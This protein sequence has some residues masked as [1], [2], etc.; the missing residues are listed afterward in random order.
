MARKDRIDRGLFERSE[1]SGVWW[2]RYAGPDGREHMERGGTKTEARTLLERR[3]TERHLGTWKP[4]AKANRGRW[5]GH[6]RSVDPDGP[7]LGAFAGQWLQERTPHLTPLVLYDYGIL[8]NTKLLPHPIARKP[9]AKIDEGDIARLVKKLSEQR[10]RGGKVLSPRRV[11]MVISRLRTIFRTARRRKIIADDPMQYVENLRESKPEYDPFD[12]DEAISLLAAAKGWERAFL[13]CLVFAGL[14]PNEALALAWN[15]IDF[16]HGLIRV[17]RNLWR[18]F[19]FGLPKTRGA[20]REVEM[21][22]LVRRE[23]RAQRARSQLRGE[24]VFPSETATPIDL[25]NFRVRN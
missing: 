10:A 16:K 14:R 12:L 22:A 1:G 19:G 11:N 13:A 20:E 3:K 9:I 4:S 6:A 21:M 2:I 7:T 15:D 25:A 18:G 8:I 24:L 17:R 23:L 5:A